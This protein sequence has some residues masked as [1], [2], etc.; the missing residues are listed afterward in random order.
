MSLGTQISHHGRCMV[1]TLKYLTRE[2]QVNK[3]NKAHMLGSLC[4]D[5]DRL[6]VARI[7]DLNYLPSGLLSLQVKRAST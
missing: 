4:M 2:E 6:I 5:S 7:I 1:S 3:Q